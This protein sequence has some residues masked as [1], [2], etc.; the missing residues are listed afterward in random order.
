MTEIFAERTDWGALL[1]D[2][3]GAGF[4][5]YAIAKAMGKSWNTVQGWRIHEPKHCDGEALKAL[6]FRHC[7]R[8]E[9]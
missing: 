3:V 4:T 1:D 2:L 8:I 7:R 5:V 9:A 6:H